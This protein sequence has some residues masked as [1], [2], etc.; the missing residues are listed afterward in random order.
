[1]KNLGSAHLYIDLSQGI[2][3]IKHGTTKEILLQRKARKG[4]WENI[5]R[6]LQCN[7]K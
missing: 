3:T 5:W 6:V 1:M 4:T 7:K 2:L